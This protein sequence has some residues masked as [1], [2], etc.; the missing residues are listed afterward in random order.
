[1]VKVPDQFYG[2]LRTAAAQTRAL[3]GMARAS[4]TIS[5]DTW[6]AGYHGLFPD[7]RSTETKYNQAK[8]LAP[9]RR[10]YGDYR[11]CEITPITAQA[12]ALKHPSQVKLLHRAW[13]F[14]TQMRVVELNV[15]KLVTMPRR[16]KPRRV[17]PTDEQLAAILARAGCPDTPFGRMIA[18]A[19]YSGARQAGLI[20]LRRVDATAHAGRLRV[21]EKGGKQRWIVLPQL[22]QEALAIQFHERQRHHWNSGGET[23]KSPHVFVGA[24]HRALKVDTVQ[25][26][27]RAVRGDFPHGFHSLRHYAATWMRERGCSELDVAVQLGHTDSDGRPYPELVRRVYDHPDPEAA[28]QRIAAAVAHG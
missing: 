19:S 16:T 24:D 5:V 21:T 9:F 28:L 22:A 1:M 20:G 10:A 23:L 6:L 8:M 17:P 2:E 4:H 27:W 15:W 3:R 26:K 14:A 12:W 25:A 7:G 13:E 18:T 11:M